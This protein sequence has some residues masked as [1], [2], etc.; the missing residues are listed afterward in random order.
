MIYATVLRMGLLVRILNNFSLSDLSPGINPFHFVEKEALELIESLN[1]NSRLFLVTLLPSD[2]N[3]S[4]LMIL[5][6]I[7]PILN[8]IQNKKGAKEK[9][10]FTLTVNTQRRILN[11][12]NPFVMVTPYSLA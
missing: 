4:F 5:K 9:L 7:E 11:Q 3:F 8:L 12:F 6:H 2:V 1:V 10:G